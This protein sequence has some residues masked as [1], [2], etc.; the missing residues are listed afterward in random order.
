MK[1]IKSKIRYVIMLPFMIM[2]LI[3][4]F[5]NDGI[6]FYLYSSVQASIFYGRSNNILEREEKL[7]ALVIADYHKIEKALALKDPRPGFGVAVVQRLV[8]NSNEYLSKFGYNETLQVALTCLQEYQLFNKK[9]KSM[10]SCLDDRINK[11]VSTYKFNEYKYRGGT[12]NVSRK[13]ILTRSKVDLTDFFAS[14][15]SIRNFSSDALNFEDLKKAVI[16]AQKAPSVCNRQSSKAYLFNKREHIDKVLSYQSGCASFSGSVNAV[17][18]V[19]SNIETFF[20][21]DERNQCWIDG[22]LFAMSLVYALHSLGIGSCCLNWCVTKNSDDLLHDV[23][24]ISKSEA[25][26]MLIACGNYPDDFKVAMSS[27]KPLDEVLITEQL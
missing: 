11:I 24:G 27:R 3:K 18:V 25:V 22:G 2:Y 10:D 21:V 12:R 19:T 6:R 16:M 26:I 4:R 23:I 14:R 1:K 5:I 7:K 15:Y 13:D 9:Y 17:Y 20:S 8:D